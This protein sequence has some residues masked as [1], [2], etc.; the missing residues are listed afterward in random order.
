LPPDFA[1]LLQRGLDVSLRD[2]ELRSAGWFAEKLRGAG[3]EEAASWLGSAQ[4]GNVNGITVPGGLKAL[5][6][7]A[8]GKE[9]VT[10]GQ[11]PLEY[12]RSILNLLNTGME[13]SERARVDHIV[14]YFDKIWALERLGTRSGRRVTVQVSVKDKDSRQ[15]AERVAKIL[16][17]QLHTSRQGVTLEAVEK[18][19]AAKRQMVAIALEIDMVGMQEALQSKGDF[20]FDVVDARV[21]ILLKEEAWR[22]QFYAG[23]NFRGGFAEA[24]ARDPRPAKLY[25]GLVGMDEEALSAVVTEIGLKT[26]ADKFVDLLLP[27]SSA[28]AVAGGHALV[29]GGVGAE[30]LWERL[31]G[32]KPAH[33]ARFFRSLL[34]KDDGKLLAF[35]FA[36]TQLDLA[37]QKFFSELALFSRTRKHA[38]S[39]AVHFCYLYSDDIFSFPW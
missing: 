31:V 12:C 8:Q 17:W 1:N 37:H 24:V 25:V 14:D 9:Q 20:S 29:P 7:V 21:P 23:E 4:P 3:H 16:G 11:F 19:T 18:S 6:F 38:A 26:L 22:S 2:G 27:Y 33:P 28:L 10:A 30:P 36:L 35:F 34:H 32:A 5:I 15:A 13:R 39:V